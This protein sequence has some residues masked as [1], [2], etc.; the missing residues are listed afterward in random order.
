MFT[1]RIVHPQPRLAH[2]RP[3]GETHDIV[4]WKSTGIQARLCSLSLLDGEKK[5]EQ[6][7]ETN[8]SLASEHRHGDTALILPDNHCVLV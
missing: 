2:P 1:L 8:V 3:Q 4:L 7:A 6:Y 5:T